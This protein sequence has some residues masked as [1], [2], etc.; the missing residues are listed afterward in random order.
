MTSR[1]VICPSWSM[2]SRDNFTSVGFSFP[3]NRAEKFSLS[4]VTSACPVSTS[5]GVEAFRPD[6]T[7]T[8]S[9]GIGASCSCGDC[10]ESWGGTDGSDS[11]V[12]A[13]CDGGDCCVQDARK[14]TI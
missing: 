14:S 1:A 3:Y 4:M 2:P 7:H 12:E 6:L 13:D 8:Q 11:P 10:G 9:L 5:K